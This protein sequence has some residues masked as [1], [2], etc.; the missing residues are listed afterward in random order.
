MWS[1]H[2][3]K[4]PTD[5]S[6]LQLYLVVIYI[7][8]EIFTFKLSNTCN[9]ENLIQFLRKLKGVVLIN[10]TVF[11]AIRGFSENNKRKDIEF[12]RMYS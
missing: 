3:S 10:T 9:K 1:F 11:Y 6:A 8:A 5:I 2:I 7:S 4:A 12:A